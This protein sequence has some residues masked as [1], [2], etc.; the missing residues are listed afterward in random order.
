MIKF[1]KVEYR[2]LLSVGNTPI[3][4][5][6]DEPG[7]FLVVGRNGAG[8]SLIG[9]ALTYGLFGRPYRKIKKGQLVNSINKKDLLVVIDFVANGK[10][11]RIRRGMKPTVFEVFCNGKLL[12]QPGD[13]RDYQKDLEEKI[14]RMN[15]EAFKQI[16]LLSKTSYKPFMDLKAN[17]RRDVIEKL[18]D[19]QVFTVMAKLLKAHRDDLT[20]EM[21][22]FDAHIEATEQTIKRIRASVAR[23][24][25]NT[26]DLVTSKKEQIRSLMTEGS[27]A[28]S[29][30]Q[31]IKVDLEEVSKEYDKLST[32]YKIRREKT[33][34]LRNK[35]QDRQR[36]LTREKEFFE[37][38]TSCPTCAQKIK[39]DYRVESVT[40][41]EET[42]RD[43]AAA[44]VELDE[45][46]KLLVEDQTVV[47]DLEG[48]QRSLQNQLVEL[49]MTIRHT[50]S[51]IE[52]LQADLKQLQQQ[53]E[54]YSAEEDEIAEL[55]LKVASYVDKKREALKLADLYKVATMLLRDTGIKAQIIK[56]YV[57]V[58]NK[59]V[60]KYLAAMD[61]FVQFELDE[62]FDEVI[63]SRFR[64][65]FSYHSF[66][67]GEKFRIDLSLLLTWRAIARLRNSCTTNLLFL[68]EIFDSSLDTVGIEDF[69]KLLDSLVAEGTTVFV[70]SH[71]G[72]Q[73]MDK[74]E[75]VIRFEK[76]RNF[77]Q[78][79]ED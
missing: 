57:P 21:I 68:D 79:I 76:V 65:D 4:I 7:S 15:Y 3:T 29:E 1:T 5:D 75:N 43:L 64:D 13:T 62:N 14:L 19:I 78:K 60:A 50:K 9:E 49:R 59:F 22:T 69:M 66:S 70:V 52:S 23:V 45:R 39:E 71:K 40:S 72:D 67:E 58:I 10:M 37:H 26:E 18:L 12:N 55:E 36:V 47:K 24:M 46:L 6:Y 53:H 54:Q 35:I 2:N 56:Q 74:F 8:K 32:A 42:L 73:L 61:F 20:K 34:Q 44:M 11:Y 63:K 33:G 41:R 51:T 38:S 48:Q 25:Q 28:V 27:S 17:E 16:V 77:T 30:M 31:K